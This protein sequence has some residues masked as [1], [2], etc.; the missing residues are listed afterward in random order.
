MELDIEFLDG[1]PSMEVG[2]Q[3]RVRVVQGDSVGGT[4]PVSL[5]R[6]QFKFQPLDWGRVQPT[7][8][9][10]IGVLEVIQVLE[11]D[12]PLLAPAYSLQAFLTTQAKRTFQQERMVR[13]VPTALE[14]E[15]AF[16]VGRKGRWVRFG[17][18]DLSKPIDWSLAKVGDPETQSLFL[19]E[20]RPF[21]RV[22]PVEGFPLHVEIAF[23]NGETASLEIEGQISASTAKAPPMSTGAQSRLQSGPQ[24]RSLE[25]TRSSSEPTT[26]TSELAQTSPEDVRDPT[27]LPREVAR[28]AGLEQEAAER[29]AAERQAAER[30]AAERQ[31]ASPV[32]GESIRDALTR[33]HRYANSFSG[34]Q[35]AK[36]PAEKAASIRARIG[37]E[38]EQVREQIE[39]YQ[40]ADR[41]ELSAI[42]SAI[43]EGLADWEAAPAAS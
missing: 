43:T 20:G 33:L 5:A 17:P 1:P 18:H 14:I 34:A 3:T 15:L 21:L 8:D 37:A 27:P 11:S 28:R 30:Q 26:A 38:S 36:L 2:H 10:G 31:A 7:D 29:Q 42:L 32:A 25:S 22:S 4:T 12:D 6:V 39:T 40:G 35:R 24:N 19:R 9:P 13:L 23:P 41:A 16:E